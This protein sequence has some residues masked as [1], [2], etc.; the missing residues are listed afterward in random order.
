MWT[1]RRRVPASRR[2][3]TSLRDG[4]SGR[5]CGSPGVLAAARPIA[6]GNVGMRLLAKMGWQEGSGAPRPLFSPVQPVARRLCMYRTQASCAG[7]LEVTAPCRGY[8]TLQRSHIHL[9]AVLLTASECCAIGRPGAREAGH[10]Q[11]AGG[12][13][14]P[15]EERARPGDSL[16][17]WGPSREEEPK[18]AEAETAAASGCLE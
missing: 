6:A 16:R 2:R 14:Q 15:Q 12:A 7:H 3:R 5:R 8:S 13:G 9:D 18:A 1:P 10:N 11:P 17:R 4:G